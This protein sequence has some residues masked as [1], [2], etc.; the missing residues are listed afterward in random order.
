MSAP[1][2]AG[3]A[4]A[5]AILIKQIYLPSF[6]DGTFKNNSLVSLFPAPQ[7]SGGDTACRWKVHSDVNGSVE[8]FTEGQVSPTPDSQEWVNAAVNYTYF[9]AAI[10]ITGHA[11][12][13]MRSN[14]VNGIEEEMTLAR[15]DVIDL[16][17]TSFLGATYGLEVS[18]D[19][20]TTYAGV[21]RGSA[22]YFE[23]YETAVSAALGY[24]NLI[25]MYQA[26]RDNDRGAKPSLILC[27]WNQYTRI[28]N[29]SGGPALR[30]NPTPD[31][32]NGYEAI[33]F[34][35]IPIKP[36][37]DMTDTVLLMLDTSPEKWAHITHRAWDVKE[38][39]PS[40]DSDVYQLS[41]A[42]TLCCKDP[43]RQGKLTGLTA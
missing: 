13:A 20:T 8:V 14:W 24:A 1:F 28:Y 3:G 33:S 35:G 42:G 7:D 31:V 12:D 9:R 19:S 30:Q 5:G 25:A 23:A 38:M 27:P 18:V 36:I 39:A 16:M 17:T 41:Y 32:A 34:N 37:P 43:M 26:L 2:Q 6:I 15:E 21:T 22:T 11:R 40:G 10:Q 29:L 4:T